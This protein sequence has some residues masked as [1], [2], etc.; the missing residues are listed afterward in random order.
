MT[1]YATLAQVKAALRITDSVDDTL[2]EMARESASDL[3]DGYYGR[4]FRQLGDGDAGVRACRRL[5]VPD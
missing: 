1:A 2:I 3:I 4:T 5:C